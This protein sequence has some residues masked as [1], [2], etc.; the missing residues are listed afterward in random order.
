MVQNHVYAVNLFF[1]L[2]FFDLPKN[3]HR[4]HRRLHDSKGASF[5]FH[6]C[7]IRLGRSCVIHNFGRKV[8]DF[9]S[10]V[11]HKA[12]VPWSLQHRWMWVLLR[13]Q[14]RSMPLGVSQGSLWVFIWVRNC[15][16]GVLLSFHF[17]G[18]FFQGIGISV[19][20]S[21]DCVGLFLFTQMLGALLKFRQKNNAHLWS[22][23]LKNMTF[24]VPTKKQNSLFKASQLHDKKTPLVWGCVLRG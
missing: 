5:I 24:D 2:L 22:P 12:K 7:C 6:D 19:Q 3:K 8:G 1:G 18:A 10:P 17:S 11:F 21:Q 20:H 16:R 9:S 15:L 13:W 23:S 14:E 4:K